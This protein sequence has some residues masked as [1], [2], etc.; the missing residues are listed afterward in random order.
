VT[1]QLIFDDATYYFG[2]TQ[3][4]VDLVDTRVEF[5]AAY[6]PWQV[7]VAYYDLSNNSVA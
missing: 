4:E 2:S 1:E 5:Q 7:V 3:L 6:C